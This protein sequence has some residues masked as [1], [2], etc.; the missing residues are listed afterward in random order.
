MAVQR[1][2]KQGQPVSADDESD[3]TVTPLIGGE[4]PSSDPA[5]PGLIV[6]SDPSFPDLVFRPIKRQDLEPLERLQK[7][8]FPVQYVS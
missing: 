3:S 1:G 5:S 8:L 4:A 7:T 6:R 2:P